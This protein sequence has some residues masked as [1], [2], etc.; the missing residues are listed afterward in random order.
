[1]KCPQCGEKFGDA[2]V[3]FGRVVNTCVCGCRVMTDA[4]EPE[5]PKMTETDV[6]ERTLED[7]GPTYESIVAIEEMGEL[8]K[9][10][11]KDLRDMGNPG[12]IAEEM[13]DVEICLAMLKIVYCNAEDVKV[14][15]AKKLKRLEDSLLE[16]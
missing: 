13:A 12:H 16:I 15:K 5:R 1:M 14:W 7:N 3:M 4:K 6:L 2:H 9:E 10:L 11:T 8:I